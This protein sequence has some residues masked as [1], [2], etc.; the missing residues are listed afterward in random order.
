MKSEATRKVWNPRVFSPIERGGE[1]A[2]HKECGYKKVWTPKGS[3]PI[4]RKEERAPWEEC[5]LKDVFVQG[6]SPI[7]REEKLWSVK[8]KE[9]KKRFCLGGSARREVRGLVFS[10]IYKLA[11]KSRRICDACINAKKYHK[12]IWSFLWKIYWVLIPREILL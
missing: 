1:R 8:P 4:R 10:E 11:Y 3:S 7:E 5:N 12:H 6:S 9:K 2:L